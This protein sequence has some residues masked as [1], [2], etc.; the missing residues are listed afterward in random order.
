M[1]QQQLIHIDNSKDDII[2]IHDDVKFVEW[3]NE[4]IAILNKVKD[5]EKANMHVYDVVAN[6][7]YEYSVKVAGIFSSTGKQLEGSMY[8]G[9]DELVRV[10]GFD[11]Q[12]FLD[13]VH[14][15][16]K[17]KLELYKY[18]ISRLWDYYRYSKKFFKK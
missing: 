13:I 10:V 16:E 17:S 12:G 9:Y 5:I 18:L 6:L 3:C 8:L 15:N 14:I 7:N 2:F 4:C 1:V 11:S